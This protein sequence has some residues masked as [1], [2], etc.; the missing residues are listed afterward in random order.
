MALFHAFPFIV[1][2]L[3]VHALPLLLISTNEASACLH[4]IVELV[5]GRILQLLLQNI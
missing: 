1:D 5:S 2:G 4:L 3:F